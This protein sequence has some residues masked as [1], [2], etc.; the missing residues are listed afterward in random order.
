MDKKT[1][2]LRGYPPLVVKSARRRRPERERLGCAGG[3][4]WHGGDERV[5]GRWAELDPISVGAKH[6]PVKLD[7]Q[8]GSI[9]QML[10]PYHALPERDAIPL[11]VPARTLTSP[12]R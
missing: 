10:R 9:G 12:M 7:V 3:K 8:S 6:L 2:L 4:L 5:L 11:Y 1:G